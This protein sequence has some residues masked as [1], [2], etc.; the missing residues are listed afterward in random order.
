[1]FGSAIALVHFLRIF[2]NQEGDLSQQSLEPSDYW[3]ITANQQTLCIEI[4]IFQQR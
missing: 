3:L 1:M 2:K 4:N